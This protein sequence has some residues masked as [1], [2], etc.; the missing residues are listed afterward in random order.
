EIGPIAASSP[1][2]VVLTSNRTR[3]LHTA[4]RR[5]CLYHWVGH[6]DAEREYQILR[7]RAPHVPAQLARQVADAVQRIRA[8][9]LGNPPGV[10]EA[11][12]WAGALHMIGS[13]S[14]SAQDAAA[15]LSAL[16]KDIDDQRLVTEQISDLVPAR[17]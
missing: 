10:G 3:D 8:L 2:L 6:P 7:V 13:A 11:I 12:D 1:P 9:A 15:T 17:P 14:L 5:R 4:L 16:V